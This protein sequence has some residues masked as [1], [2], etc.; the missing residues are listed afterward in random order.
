MGRDKIRM[1]NDVAYSKEELDCDWLRKITEKP[2][3]K[4]IE[5]K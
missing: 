4:K 1:Q 3:T 5:P 2:E